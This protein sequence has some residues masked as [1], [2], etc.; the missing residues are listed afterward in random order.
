MKGIRAAQFTNARTSH[1][2]RTW[3]GVFNTT[4]RKGKRTVF[5]SLQGLRTQSKEKTGGAFRTSWNRKGG[6]KEKGNQVV[7]TSF[8][9]RHRRKA[10]SLM[11]ARPIAIYGH[12]A[13]QML[14]GRSAKKIM[15]GLSGHVRKAGEKNPNLKTKTGKKD[16]SMLRKE[17]EKGSQ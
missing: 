5:L 17:W 16:R 8:T 6:G 14:E 1:G 2:K 12:Q 3:K 10:G 11:E 4:K 15:K 13:Q 7:G 9:V